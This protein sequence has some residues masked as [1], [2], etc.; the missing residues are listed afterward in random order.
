MHRRA[1]SLIADAG[2]RRDRIAGQLLQTDPAGDAW[3]VDQLRGAAAAAVDAGDPETSGRLLR[4]ALAEPAPAELRAE[5]LC[6]LGAVELRSHA[7]GAI[8]HLFLAHELAGDARLRVAVVRLLMLALMGAGRADE[9]VDLL[10]PA[11][12]EATAL[13]EDL[14]LQVEAEVI[15]LARLTT[16]PQIGHTR[17][18]RR[19]GRIQ[20]R[21]PGERLLLADLCIEEALGGSSA[22]HAART[23][24][25]ALGD[26]ALLS[27]QTADTMPFY[28]AVYV[29]GG[30]ER[31]DRA[32][33]LLDV[34]LADAVARGSQLGFAL[35]SLFRSYVELVAGRVGDAEAEAAN[36]L[37]AADDRVWSTGFPACIAATVDVLAVQ[38]RTA[39]AERLLQEHDLHGPL[40]DSVP[41]RVLLHSRAQLRIVASDVAGAMADYDEFER[42]EATGPTLH[43]WLNN[44]RLGVVTTLVRAGRVP[45]AHERA[46]AAVA[47]ARHWGTNHAV[48]R[49]QIALAAAS[50]PDEAAVHLI[51]AAALLAESPA[52]LDLAAALVELGALQRRSG[53]RAAAEDALRRGFDLASRVGST[54]QAERAR[55]ELI[56]LGRRPR[57]AAMTGI[58]ALT[59]SER[60]VADL[61][62]GGMSNREIAQSLFVTTR[63][64]ETHLSSAYRKLGIVSRSDLPDALAR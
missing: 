20:G 21:T 49:A 27:E 56:A 18:V 13:D 12:A 31:L 52:R 42:R 59:G 29:L 14:G 28:Q 64:V 11:I 2:R 44:H 50:P 53:A 7:P 60:R 24:E 16:R 46:A 17:S 10:G 37:R 9:A 62:A 30:A 41:H 23:A 47:A 3:V 1:A 39:L 40:P 15:S 32:G 22:D 36:A 45:E 54:L 61:A 33:K 43:P 51:Q 48:G 6:E 63:T 34:A 38:G 58:D 25:Q 26:G 19:R 57:R 35:A 8:E 4:R 5:L 55:S